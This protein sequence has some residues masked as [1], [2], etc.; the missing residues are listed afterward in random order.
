V[1]RLRN[2]EEEESQLKKRA[3]SLPPLSLPSLVLYVRKL[4][5]VGAMVP[6]AQSRFS[7]LVSAVVLK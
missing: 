2:K 5:T 6:L 1:C 4:L 3:L 7:A